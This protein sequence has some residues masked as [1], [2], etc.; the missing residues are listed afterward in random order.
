MISNVVL[1]YNLLCKI[2]N[3]FVNMYTKF[4]PYKSTVDNWRNDA[5]Q[6]QDLGLFSGS[7]L[8]ILV[9]LFCLSQKKNGNV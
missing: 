4:R 9:S 6:N 3:Y 1:F 7:L 8:V 2:K 5:I